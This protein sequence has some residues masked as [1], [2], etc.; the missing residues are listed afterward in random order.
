MS[1]KRL[2]V[3]L[4]PLGLARSKSH[5]VTF[6]L[7][8]QK[9][10]NFLYRHRKIDIRKEA[11]IASSFEHPALNRPSLAAWN[12]GNDS[13]IGMRLGKT[14]DYTNGVIGTAI[15]HNDYFGFVPLLTQKGVETFQR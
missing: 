2:V 12:T 4:G 6:E 11:I 10:G 5:I 1:M 3:T 9:F 8:R 14:F 7:R 13:N 15:F